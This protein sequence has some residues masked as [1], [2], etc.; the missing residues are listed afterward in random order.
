MDCFELSVELEFCAAH[1]LVGHSG[2]C[3]NLHG[4]NYKVEVSLKGS[5]LNSLGILV[6]FTDIK[7]AAKDIIE[8]L[9]HKNINDIDYPPF[10]EGK[11]SA[12]N[13]SKYIYK[14]LKEKL[15]NDG[16][17]VNYIKVWETSKA[18]VKYFETD[19]N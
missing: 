19:D 3:A 6:D 2:K 5:K 8:E 11:S 1:T 18:S 16:N 17:L 9:D 7:N 13:I 12:E 15:G 4:H 10:K 14:K